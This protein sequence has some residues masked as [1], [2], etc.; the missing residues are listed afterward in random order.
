MILQSS[1]ADI[2]LKNYYR[3][4]VPSLDDF[5]AIDYSVNGPKAVFSNMPMS[6]TLTMNLDVPEPW[7]V[8]PVVAMYVAC[9]QKSLGTFLYLFTFTNAHDHILPLPILSDISSIH[10]P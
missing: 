7:L 10:F 1:L 8:E 6:K 2:P 3:F 5:S 9:L 4:V